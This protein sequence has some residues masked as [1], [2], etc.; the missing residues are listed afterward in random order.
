MNFVWLKIRLHKF[1]KVYSKILVYF[2]AYLL[3][4]LK[5]KLLQPGIKP[6]CSNLF[7][8]ALAV[9]YSKKIV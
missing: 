4:N 6:G 9:A 2:I 8:Y 5:K 3:Q 7:L 1:V